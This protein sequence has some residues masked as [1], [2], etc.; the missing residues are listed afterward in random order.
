MVGHTAFG[1]LQSHLIP[2]PFLCGWERHSFPGNV[3][4]NDMVISE[5]VVVVNPGDSGV[6]IGYQADEFS[7][8]WSV[9]LIHFPLQLGCGDYSLFSHYFLSRQKTL[10]L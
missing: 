3:Q 10:M 7:H 9:A 5:S 1:A 8:T 4:S 2:L 6:V